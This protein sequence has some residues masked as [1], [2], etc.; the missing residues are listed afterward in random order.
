M[1]IEKH[2]R[3]GDPGRLPDDGVLVRTDAEASDAMGAARRDRRDPP[4]LGLLGGDLARTCGA[5]GDEARLRGDEAQTLPVDVG[6]ALVDG[7]LRHFV[8]HVVVRRPF[9]RGRVL[10]VMNAQYL[11][12]WNVAPRSHPNDGRLDVLDADP[13][14]GERWKVRARLHT[15]THLPHPDISV[16]R[17]TGAQFD[18]DRGT[19]VWVD[20]RSV[21]AAR[22][23]SVRI[24]PDALHVVV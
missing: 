16:R 19:R 12:R 23:L 15:G 9:W 18:L 6:E 4:V 17:V 21:G 24:E 13:P 5:T 1:T 20:G 7:V 10:A 2:E 11:G 8:A 3:W 14:L 22:A